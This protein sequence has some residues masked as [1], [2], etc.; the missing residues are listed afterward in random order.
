M[1]TIILSGGELGGYEVQADLTEWAP[2]ADREFQH[3]GVTYTYR[4]VSRTQAVL[5]SSTQ[6]DPFA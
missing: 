4:R 1:D 3:E 5:A 2:H 6:P